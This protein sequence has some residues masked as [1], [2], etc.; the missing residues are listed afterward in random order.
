MVK[1]ECSVGVPVLVSFIE[2]LFVVYRIQ[3][4]TLYDPNDTN[5]FIVGLQTAKIQMM[6]YKTLEICAINKTMQLTLSWQPTRS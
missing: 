6:I 2:V 4:V 5:A 3:K 1:A